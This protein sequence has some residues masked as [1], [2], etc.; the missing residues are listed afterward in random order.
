MN[1]RWLSVDRQNSFIETLNIW[2][3]RIFIYLSVFF[4]KHCFKKTPSFILDLSWV[5]RSSSHNVLSVLRETW[6]GEPT[7]P[8]HVNVM[9]NLSIHC[10]SL[11]EN[12]KL[13]FTV[14]LALRSDFWMLF[15]LIDRARNQTG[16]SFAR[17]S[18]N[19]RRGWHGSTIWQFRSTG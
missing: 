9:I 5:A 10:V 14:V 13:S 6:N 8:F 15:F 4:Y 12:A 1:S 17:D 18:R 7:L 3:V 19:F 2:R 16:I 11:T